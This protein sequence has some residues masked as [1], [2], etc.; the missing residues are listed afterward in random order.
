MWRRESYQHSGFAVSL[1]CACSA[2]EELRVDMLLLVSEIVSE[3]DVT[4]HGLCNTLCYCCQQPRSAKRRD[5]LCSVTKIVSLEKGRLG[6][7]LS[8]SE[9]FL[10]KSCVNIV[11]IVLR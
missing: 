5:I 6:D 10:K 9:H 8:R 1:M 3:G 7:S 11:L 4:L 2:R